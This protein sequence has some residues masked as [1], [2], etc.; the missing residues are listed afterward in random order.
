MCLADKKK[1][2]E[3]DESIE[4]NMSSV[5]EITHYQESASASASAYSYSLS[6]DYQIS[7]E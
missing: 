3:S 7:T 6:S 4:K 5:S 2:S 1:W